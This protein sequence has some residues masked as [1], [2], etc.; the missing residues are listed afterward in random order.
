VIAKLLQID[1]TELVTL[2]LADKFIAAI[3]TETELAP[4]AFK[5]AFEKSK[6]NNLK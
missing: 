3:G 1:E 4:K 6:N 5:V 2:W